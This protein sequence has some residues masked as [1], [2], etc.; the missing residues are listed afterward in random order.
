MY[1][2]TGYNHITGGRLKEDLLEWMRRLTAANP[3][4]TYIG[5]YHFNILPHF[6][7]EDDIL[8]DFVFY[9]WNT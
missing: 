9:N 4:R 1:A 3:D 7:Q 8:K 2:D 6:E 5:A